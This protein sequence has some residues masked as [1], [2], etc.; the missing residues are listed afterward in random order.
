MAESVAKN[1]V[2][3]KTPFEELKEKIAEARYSDKMGEL[4]GLWEMSHCFEG[5]DTLDTR[6]TSSLTSRRFAG[7]VFFLRGNVQTVPSGR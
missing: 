2:H 4:S 7:V 3:D 5:L 6:L 1:N